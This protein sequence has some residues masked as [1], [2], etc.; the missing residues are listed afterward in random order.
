MKIAIGSDHGGYDLKEVIVRYLQKN[1][2]QTIDFGCHGKDSVDY[3]DFGIG[4]ARAVAS[5]SV[6]RGVLICTTGIGMSIAANKVKGIRAALCTDV[7][8]ARMSRQH[9]DANILVLGAKIVSEPLALDIV[10]E[11][12]TAS[13]EGGRHQRRIDKIKELEK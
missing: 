1:G 2:H 7:L 5:G 6:D 4:V 3:P 13:F 11:W 10:K 9:N 12:I 8:T